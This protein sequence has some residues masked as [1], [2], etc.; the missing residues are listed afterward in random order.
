ME[1]AL[2]RSGC[3]HACRVT[4]GWEQ[5]S[6]PPPLWKRLLGGGVVPMAG[7]S[8]PRP[9]RAAKRSEFPSPRLRHPSPTCGE[10]GAGRSG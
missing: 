9:W 3:P 2:S 6:S 10:R 4:E 5:L 1:E 7:S 8:C